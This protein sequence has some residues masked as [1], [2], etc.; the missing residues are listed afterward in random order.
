MSCKPWTAG[1]T[2]KVGR[3]QAAVLG[4]GGKQSGSPRPWDHSLADPGPAPCQISSSVL[5]GMIQ[6]PSCVHLPPTIC[7]S[8]Q[9]M[10]PPTLFL[11]PH[12]N[13]KEESFTGIG[14][15][16][17]KHCPWTVSSTPDLQHLHCTHPHSDLPRGSA[18]LPRQ[19]SP[20]LPGSAHYPSP[21]ASPVKL[22][23]P[24]PPR[25][26]Q[27][28][29]PHPCP[30]RAQSPHGGLGHYSELY[31]SSPAPQSSRGPHFPLEKSHSPRPCSRQSGSPG[32][33]LIPDCC[34]VA[35]WP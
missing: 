1:S 17:P 11:H 29:A 33:G 22:P 20:A 35:M 14:W 7:T 28:L 32:S 16:T 21:P 10:P 8:S 5:P 31:M 18:P 23:T 13:S 24:L 9:L 2:P 12:P 25:R 15:G 19:L 3:T 4:I 6:K 26:P 34:S 27:H 30:Q